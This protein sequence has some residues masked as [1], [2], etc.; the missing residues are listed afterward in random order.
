MV[1]K[2]SVAI[3]SFV[4]VFFS[5]LSMITPWATIVSSSTAVNIFMI[6]SVTASSFGTTFTNTGP[7]AGNYYVAGAVAVTFV[8]I[9]FLVSLFTLMMILQ[10]K[11]QLALISSFISLVCC[12]ISWTVYAGLVSPVV[13]NISGNLSAGFAFQ[14]I[15]MVIT[16]LLMYLIFAMDVTESADGSSKVDPPIVVSPPPGMPIVVVSA[17]PAVVTATK[18]SS[19]AP[20]L[21]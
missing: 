15:Y 14:I 7:N 10:P 1:S 13:K 11:K 2:N 19:D 6:T 18:E 20:A 21:V 9:E 4:Q 8:L 17:P 3:V 12:V 5:F 16:L